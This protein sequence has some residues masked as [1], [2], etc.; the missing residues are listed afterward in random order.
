VNL[1]QK[2]GKERKKE[3]KKREANM[4]GIELRQIASSPPAGRSS[5]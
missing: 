1:F 2:E 3:R 4:N 5:Q